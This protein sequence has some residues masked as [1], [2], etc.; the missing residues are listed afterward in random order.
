M[1]VPH[2]GRSEAARC[3][4]SIKVMNR[5]W[6]F[7]RAAGTPLL[8]LLCLADWADDNGECWPSI[9]TI[10]TKCRLKDDRHVRRVIR[11]LVQIDEVVIIEGGGHS[12][13][14]GGMR[15]NRYRITVHMPEESQTLAD[16]PPLA[17]ADPGSQTPP[18][19]GSQTPQTLADR[20]PEPSGTHQLESSKTSVA[21]DDLFSEVWALYPKKVDRGKASKAYT[22]RRKAG[23]TQADLLSATRNYAA[24]IH[25]SGTFVKN[26]ATFFGP[27][28]PYADFVGGIP[29]GAMANGAHLGSQSMAAIEA[30]TALFDQPNRSELTR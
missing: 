7:S 15:S 9:A 29:D 16:R 19:G 21:F 4:V 18:D 8:V 27:D 2:A 1:A 12:S 10:A 17:N 5:V 20:P 26:G 23:A 24:W 14:R 28:E 11:S 3:R 30:A 6:D 22:A 25:A 13:A